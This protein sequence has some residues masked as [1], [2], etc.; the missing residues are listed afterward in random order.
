VFLTGQ[1]EI[2]RAVA[3][4]NA[5]VC[6]LPEGA[7]A[8]LLVLPLYAA[9]PPE[10]QLRVFRPPP[11][12]ASSPA[13]PAAAGGAQQQQ[14]QQQ[15]QRQRQQ[16][17]RRCIVATNVAETS[18]TV[19]GVV[20]VVD[21]G[22]MKL[23]SYKAASGMDSLDVVAISRVQA[24]QRAG[25]A[26]RTRPGKVRALQRAQGVRA[27]VIRARV[28]V[29]CRRARTPAC[30]HP[31]PTHVRTHTRARARARVRSATA[32]TRAGTTRPPCP[33]RR[34][35]RSAA[36]AWRA[37]CC[38]SRRCGCR[39]WTCCPLAFWTRLSRCVCGCVCA[40]CVHGR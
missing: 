36:P 32:C 17:V 7:A 30:A 29:S 26:G 18:I 2:E 9:L 37:R 22:V 39:G 1:A 25:R 11:P 5:A 31:A 6:A 3:R 10:L 12:R 24:A 14:Q 38:S 35:P 27:C 19:E 13:A 28:L 15:Q 20:Y 23:K 4:L 40:W 8:D 21:S 16:A 34:R 33:T